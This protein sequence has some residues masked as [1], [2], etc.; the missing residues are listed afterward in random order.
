MSTTIKIT[1][2]PVLETADANTQNTVF[3][4]VD[5]SSGNFTTKQFSLANLD[6]AVDNVAS[7]AFTTA[8]A[9]FDQA[10]TATTISTS[11]FDEA[12]SATV[13][14]QASFDLANTTSNTLILVSEN[15]NG[16]YDLANTNQSQLSN[17]VNVVVFVD[18]APT[19]PLGDVGDKKGQ[20]FLGNTEFYYCSLDYDGTTNVWSKIVSS[21]S[22]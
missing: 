21:D 9:A 12:N 10:N 16:A 5:K 8:N 15:A 11:A 19:S 17:L 20:V 18:T 1:D 7:F 22:W 3:V 4:V 2:L 14:A 13:L 6:I